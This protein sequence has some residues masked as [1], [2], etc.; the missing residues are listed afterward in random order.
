MECRQDWIQFSSV[1]YFIFFFAPVRANYRDSAEALKRLRQVT[2][3]TRER[4]ETDNMNKTVPGNKL[5]NIRTV[6]LNG[7]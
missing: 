7:D 4:L 5:N 1:F 6:K 2:T 3:H